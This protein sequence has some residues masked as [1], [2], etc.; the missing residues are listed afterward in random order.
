MLSITTKKCETNASTRHSPLYKY[1]CSVAMFVR[2]P[3]PP[4][5]S[6]PFRDGQASCTRRRRDDKSDW[7]CDS[8]GTKVDISHVVSSGCEGIHNLR[9]VRDMPNSMRK[10][11]EAPPRVTFQ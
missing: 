1:A 8:E 4:G 10:K 3:F 11:V 7:G 6:K 5:I 9:P 2:G